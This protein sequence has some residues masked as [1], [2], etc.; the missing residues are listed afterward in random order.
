[1]KLVFIGAST[2]GLKCLEAC[3][4][5]PEVEVTGI[6]TAPK[7][8][9][10]SYNPQ[11][12][13]N[14]LHGDVFETA[15]AHNIP[16]ATLERSMNELGLLET[17]AAW[18]PDAFLVAGWYHMIPKRWR[19]LAPAFGLHASL[20][21][22]YSGGAPLVWAIINGETRTGITLFQ[23]NDGVDS[24]PIAGQREEPIY[25]D[26]TIAT[27]Y[28]RIEQQG[29]IL[30]RESLPQMASGALKLVPQDETKRRLVPQRSPAD[31]QIDWTQD[32][33]TVERFIRA[34]TRPYPGAFST[35][36]GKPL[37]IWAA[38]QAS[39]TEGN[40]SGQVHHVDDN[41]YTVRCGTASIQL[42]E[43]SYES[44]TYTR[45]ELARLFG[46]GGQRLGVSP[47]C[48]RRSKPC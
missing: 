30:I 7:T 32:A 20:L 15:L 31:G 9:S 12:V 11:G 3:L 29:L 25:P 33:K 1:M 26:D 35:L 10:I 46:G 14:V 34:Q 16:A 40:E 36:E 27:L 19:E 18:E 6:V 21:P 23:M 42:E 37:H 4:E 48:L 8:F 45:S 17:V 47:S 22:D 5:I 43:I 41:T 44:E 38:T 2:F 39:S 28:A 24:G 13:T